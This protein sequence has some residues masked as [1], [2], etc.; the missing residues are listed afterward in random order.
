VGDPVGV[1]RVDV[2]R[3]LEVVGEPLGGGQLGDVRGHRPHLVQ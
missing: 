2:D 1:E 3:V